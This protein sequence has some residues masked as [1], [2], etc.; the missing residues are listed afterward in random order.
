VNA[1]GGQ[2]CCTP[3][4]QLYWVG[5]VNHIGHDRLRIVQPYTEP[6]EWSLQV[7]VEP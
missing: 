6:Q 1:T 5:Q 3:G 2:A 7:T 4:L